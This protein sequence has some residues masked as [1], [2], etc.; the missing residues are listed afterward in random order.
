M[1]TL[2]TGLLTALGLALGAVGL[3]AFILLMDKLAR[4]HVDTRSSGADY[5][6]LVDE[7]LDTPAVRPDSSE[8]AAAVRALVDLGYRAP[9]ARRLVGQIV[10][11]DPTLDA[12]GILRTVVARGM[13][14]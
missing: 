13:G 4:Q 1:I 9:D 7:V 10:D 6:G 14:R 5:D 2:V 11:E 8:V 3:A 12:E